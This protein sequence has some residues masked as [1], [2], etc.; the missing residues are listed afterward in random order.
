MSKKYAVVVN[1]D[2][3]HV[4]HRYIDESRLI[5]GLFTFGGINV[6]GN[7]RDPIISY[8]EE[9]YIPTHDEITCGGRFGCE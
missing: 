2:G 3:I 4:T 8:K 5:D 7:R 1:Q 9:K 6:R